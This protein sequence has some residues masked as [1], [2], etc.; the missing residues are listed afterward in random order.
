MS[1]YEYETADQMISA[2]LA[3]TSVHR[4]FTVTCSVCGY[5][6]G[7]EYEGAVHYATPREAAEM[8]H[9]S[10]Y[11]FAGGKWFCPDHR[12]DIPSTDADS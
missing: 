3:Q 1:D 8:A 12:P 11:T 9:D 4:C 7:E 2:G 5:Q 10:E 6:P